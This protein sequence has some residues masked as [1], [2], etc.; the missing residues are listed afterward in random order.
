MERNVVG[1]FE[2]PVTNLDRAIAFYEAVFQ[3]KMARHQVGDQEM[4]WFPW[5]DDPND[6][7]AAGSLV[8]HPDYTPSHE[9]TMVYF[10]CDDCNT[11][12]SRVAAAGGKILKEK[13]KIGEG[14]GFYVE[15]LDTE[16]NKIALHSRQ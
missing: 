6:A 15:V 3:F 16:G 12:A 11:E 7:G 9:G 1:W 4:G 8:K 10:S 13:T 14:Y 5:S 2:I